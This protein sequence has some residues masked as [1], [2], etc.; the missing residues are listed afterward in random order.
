[1]ENRKVKLL[2]NNLKRIIKARNMEPLQNKLY[3]FIHLNCGF[4]AHYSLNGFKQEYYEGQE[5][6][7]FL[8]RLQEGCYV[9]NCDLEDN[10]NYGY[11]NKEVKEAIREVITDKLLGEIQQEVNV[12]ARGERYGEYQRL[13][14][15]F[16]GA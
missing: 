12:A 1:M 11:T 10:Y 2:I 6:Q 7:T 16:G 15:E 4:I 3:Q 13:K 5:F 14:A 8:E 9:H